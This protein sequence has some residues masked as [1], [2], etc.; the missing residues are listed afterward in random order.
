MKVKTPFF[1]LIFCLFAVPVSAQIKGYLS[2]QFLKSRDGGQIDNG[3]FANPLLGLMFLGDITAN[4]AYGAEFRVVDVS[5]LEIDQAWVGLSS[6]DAFRFQLGLYLVPFGI[7]NQINRPHQTALIAAPLNVQY[8]YP[9][10]WR[11][12]GLVAEGRFSGFVYSVYIGNGLKEGESLQAGQQFEDNNKDKGKGG[13]FGFSLSQG[14]EVAYSI[15][16]SKYDGENS[17]GLTLHGADL[18]WTTQDW[19]VWAEYTKAIVHNPE[20][21]ITG[22]AEGYFFQALVFLGSFQPFASYQRMQYTDPYHGPGF[23]PTSGAGAGISM[24]KS[25]WAVGLRYSPVSDLFVTLEYDFNG[26]EGGEKKA[27]LWAVQVAFSF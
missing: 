7:Y 4:V 16:H 23:S 20:G 9:A 10:H 3:T 19:H 1:L 8:C 17:R 22:D 11:D 6:S 21:F 27:D 25:R 24:D 12:I 2:S 15:H 13:R 26:K 14:F 18:N 5:R